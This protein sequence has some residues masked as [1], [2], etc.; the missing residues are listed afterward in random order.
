MPKSIFTGAHKHLVQVLVDARKEAG[1]TQAQLAAAVGK[2]QSFISIIEGG[3]RRVDVIEFCA[4]ARAMGHDPQD[5]FAK[6]AKALP[7]TIVI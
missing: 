4:L 7:V 3:Q 5:L 1:M 6:L 2:D